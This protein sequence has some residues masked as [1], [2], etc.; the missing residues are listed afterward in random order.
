[1]KHNHK[2]IH[3]YSRNKK[4][5]ENLNAILNCDS[6]DD[7]KKIE[8]SADLYLIAIADNGIEEVVKEL[9]K[10]NGIVVHTSGSTDITFLKN[11]SQRYGV[12]WPMVSVTKEMR[13]AED[14][15]MIV[16]ASDADTEKKLK[17]IASLFTKN[18]ISLSYQQRQLLHLAAVFAN[19]FPNHLIAIAQKLLVENKIDVSV[20]QPMLKNMFEKLRKYPAKELQ[21]GP[22]LRNDTVTMQK[23]LQLLKDKPE[24]AE[25]YEVLSESIIRSNKS[26]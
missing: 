14:F 11:I 7:L 19:N 12:M 22:A 21:S 16:E 15:A 4:H 8:T 6:T 3:V 9:P 2:I 25:I 24:L 26:L 23:H 10:L 13:E 20:L 18:L 1:M 5:A 17:S